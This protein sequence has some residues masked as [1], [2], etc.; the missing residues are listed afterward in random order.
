MNLLSMA[1]TIA[2]IGLI[3]AGSA[4]CVPAAIAA[5]FGWWAADEFSFDV[6]VL[7]GLMLLLMLGA[8]A[9]ATLRSI[10]LWI[11]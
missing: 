6:E 8:A 1:F 2:A 10:Y 4:W 5:G 3:A 9:Y 11:S 7:G